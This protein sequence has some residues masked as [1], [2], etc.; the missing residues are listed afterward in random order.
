MAKMQMCFITAQYF[1]P[2]G[3]N[4][5]GPI[6]SGRGLRQGDPISP[7]LFIIGAEG[8]SALISKYEFEGLIYG[9]RLAR[10]APTISHL[11]F[12]DDSYLF[13]NLRRRSVCLLSGC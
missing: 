6:V 1:I 2:F 5:I 10:S 13:F 3:E 9:C 12:V 8:F 7:K 11:F 4:I